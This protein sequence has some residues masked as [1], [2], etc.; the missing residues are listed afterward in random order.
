MARISLG[1]PPNLGPNAQYQDY[2]PWLKR[3]FFENMCAYCGLPDPAVEIDHYEP[4]QYAPHRYHDPT[5]LL[6]ACS[7]CNGRGGKSDYH[8]RHQYRT[9][10]PHDRTGFAVIDVRQENP[11][12]LLAI[13]QDGSIDPRPVNGSTARASWLIVLLKLRRFGRRRRRKELLDLA[14]ACELLLQERRRGNH[15]AQHALNRLMPQLA[16]RLRFFETFDLS[17]SVGLRAELVLLRRR[18]L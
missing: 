11:A 10:L 12:D 7:R 13:G 2:L 8:H 15:H 9:R 16:R 18:L 14:L 5:N 17:L 4:R 6:L 1:N 3:S